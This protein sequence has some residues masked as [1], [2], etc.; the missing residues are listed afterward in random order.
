M[1]QSDLTF[2]FLFWV[3]TKAREGE[4]WKFKFRSKYGEVKKQYEMAVSEVMSS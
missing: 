2:M 4:V 1:K 3:R